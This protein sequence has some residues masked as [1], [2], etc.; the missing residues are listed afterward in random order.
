MVIFSKSL[1]FMLALSRDHS[2]Y[3]KWHNTKDTFE[4]HALC[5]FSA[6]SL[7]RGRVMANLVSEP[8]FHAGKCMS[9]LKP[10]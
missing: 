4:I 8:R 9:L 5:Y 10:P 1:D 6:I 3:L 7:K 2:N